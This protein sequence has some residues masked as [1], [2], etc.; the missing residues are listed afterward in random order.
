MS[1]K[2]KVDLDMMHTGGSDRKAKRN[3][4]ISVKD[5]AV[6]V[7]EQVDDRLNLKRDDNMAYDKRR[8]ERYKQIRYS[9]PMCYPLSFSI[10]LQRFA[11]PDKKSLLIRFPCCC[12]DE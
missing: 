5:L 4:C 11:F 1:E 2:V 10:S 7:A 9:F 3:I 8:T 6:L 12:G